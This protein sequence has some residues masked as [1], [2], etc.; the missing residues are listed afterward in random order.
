MLEMYNKNKPV[1]CSITDSTAFPVQHQGETPHVEMTL[2]SRSNN[3]AC[4]D[5]FGMNEFLLGVTFDVPVGTY[6][7]LYGTDD[8]LRRGYCMPQ[9]KIVTSADSNEVR[10][11]LEKKREVQDLDLPYRGGIIGVPHACHFTRMKRGKASTVVSQDS[12]PP[13]P[14]YSALSAS[15]PASR[16]MF[17]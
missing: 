10:V 11:V 16:R 15:V 7:V 9:P 6:L 3:R 8:L 14:A 17:E 1:L 5:S 4:D 13:Q 2:V 12:R